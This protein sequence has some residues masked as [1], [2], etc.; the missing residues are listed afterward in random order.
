MVIVI[1]MFMSLL[2]H[3][4]MKAPLSRLLISYSFW[5]TW[6]SEFDGLPETYVDWHC[7]WT[8]LIWVRLL[9]TC[10][11]SQCVYWSEWVYPWL[12]LTFRSELL[13]LGVWF[14]K[15]VHWGEFLMDGTCETLVQIFIWLFVTKA[16]KGRIFPDVC[17]GFRF[18]NL[19]FHPP[20]HLL[21]SNNIY[22][23]P[24]WWIPRNLQLLREGK[25]RKQSHT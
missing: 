2:G 14:E 7:L 16:T 15:C 25:W 17:W 23:T 20:I 18:S 3:R 19:A 11:H 21:S 22:Y 6:G 1:I 10:W 4:T 9:L 13:T 12:C 24:W 8:M 5:E